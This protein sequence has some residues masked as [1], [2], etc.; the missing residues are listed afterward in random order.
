MNGQDPRVPTDAIEISLQGSS[1]EIRKKMVRAA[2]EGSLGLILEATGPEPHPMLVELLQDAGRLGFK[3]VVFR[4]P[5][6]HLE[7][8]GERRQVALRKIHQV[9]EI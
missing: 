1:R 9:E 3:R 2:Q 7:S 4:A 6:H 5:V 8:L